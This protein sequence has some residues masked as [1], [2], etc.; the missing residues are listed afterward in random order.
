MSKN[1]MKEEVLSTD[2][3][4]ANLAKALE[5]K[6]KICKDMGKGS[7]MCL[8]DKGDM[9]IDVISTGSLGVDIALGVGGLPRGRMVEI[10]G[11]ESCLDRA[12]FIPFEIWSN[13]LTKRINHKG[14]TIKRLYERFHN[15]NLGEPKQG[16]HLQK[17]DVKFFVKSVNHE[18]CIVRNEVLDI[19][20]TGMKECY[21]IYTPYG[22]IT[23]TADH[24]F[25]TPRG[26][27]K[28]SDLQVGSEIYTHNNTRNIGRE[29]CLNRPE[30][31]VR[32]HP[33]LPKKVING[34][35]L[36]YRGQTSRIAYEAY[37]NNYTFQEYVDV[38]NGEFGDRIDTLKFLPENVHVHHID[39]NFRNNDISNLQ[40]I[41]P[42]EHGKLHAK[43]RKANLSFIAVPTFVCNIESIGICETYD[44]RCA[45]PYNNY[46]ANG[47]VVHNCGKTTLAIHTIAEAQ[48]LGGLCAFIDAEHC[49]DKAYAKSLG[50][51]IDEL[52]FSQPDN[53]D[54]ALEITERLISSGAYDVVVVDSVAAL[55]PKGEL[56]GEMGEN[57]LGLHAR[58][59]SQA[60]RKLVGTVSKNNTLL[61]FI[62]Q[63][64]E[65]IGVMFGSP[66]VVTGGNSLKFY[67]SVRLDIRRSLT[68]A[69]AVMDGE[70]KVGNQ[71]TVKV[72]KNKVAPPFSKCEFDIIYGEG[73]DKLGEIVEKAVELDIINKAGSWFTHKEE[74]RIQG[75]DALKALLKDNPELA[76]EIEQQIR[77][78]LIR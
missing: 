74:I 24:K 15:V 34:R 36:Y 22:D 72:I 62:N 10:Y 78:K 77:T 43:D 66:E 18:N 51:N 76:S 25:M 21:G 45:F 2:R 7:V 63:L 46:V 29:A 44:I 60:C 1:V 8:S 65:K 5:A 67:A 27:V 20:S 39:E 71:T 54:Q 48:K 17:K 47:L 4:E 32:Y 50:V 42:S 14:G 75:K 37:L 19:V 12:T 58:L 3:K 61:I 57:K 64:R 52:D 23:A 31:L 35:Y 53:G 9:D 26:F 6:A 30:T 73:I 59:M 16:R 68:A 40:L 28:L 13:D 38:L 49:F 55:I 70:V 41:A 33:H 69:N 56:E 11:P